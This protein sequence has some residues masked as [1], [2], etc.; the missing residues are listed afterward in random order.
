M[1]CNSD[2]AILYSTNVVNMAGIFEFGKFKIIKNINQILN[3]KYKANTT[4]RHD[5]YEGTWTTRLFSHYKYILL[6]IA[7]LSHQYLLITS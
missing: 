7:Y 2:F 3:T 5:T 4:T 6:P 1:D